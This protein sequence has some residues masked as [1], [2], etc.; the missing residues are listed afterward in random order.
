MC[1]FSKKIAK[2][3]KFLCG[4]QKGKFTTS[5]I[6]KSR[7]TAR[8]SNQ[9]THK[10]K[11]SRSAEVE[12]KKKREVVYAQL[13]TPPPYDG[14]LPPAAELLRYGVTVLRFTKNSGGPSQLTTQEWRDKFDVAL[15]EPG[16]AKLNMPRFAEVTKENPMFLGG[17]SAGGDATVS[18]NMVARDLREQV[19]HELVNHLAN[20]II[21]ETGQKFYAK[22]SIG[23]MIVRA[24]GVEPGSEGAHQDFC[25]V[26][27]PGSLHYGGWVNLTEQNQYFVCLKGSHGG[28]QKAGGFTPLKI[29]QKEYDAAIQAQAGQ[30]NTNEKGYIVVPPGC[31]AQ[32]AT[33]IIHSVHS[34]KS[35]SLY[36]KL[37]VGLRLTLNP[38]SCTLKHH[39]GHVI[40]HAELLQKLIDQEPALCGS[41]QFPPEL[42]GLYC[43]L[44]QHMVKWHKYKDAHIRPGS[45][46]YEDKDFRGNHPKKNGDYTRSMH[47]LRHISE[48][49][50]GEVTMYPPYTEDQTAILFPGN[51][52]NVVNPATGERVHLALQWPQEEFTDV[53]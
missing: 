13:P 7:T 41:S 35:K 25:M 26:S 3:N 6:S 29:N 42:P 10:K 46:L 20:P 33:D 47:G 44:T 18:H 30:H 8:M 45:M 32:F 27:D 39:D 1:V 24:V 16:R 15:S 12:P 38:T 28:E 17:F 37:F 43:S 2:N 52:F 5:F 14:P 11:R 48:L 36:V 4:A 53:K 9:M 51:A 23:R 50:P 19:F 49:Y 40:T 31:I 34:S 21:Q 22:T